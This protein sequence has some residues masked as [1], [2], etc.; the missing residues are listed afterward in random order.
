MIKIIFYATLVIVAKTQWLAR[1]PLLE[2][3]I[4]NLTSSQIGTIPEKNYDVA[5][6]SVDSMLKKQLDIFDTTMKAF[7]VASKKDVGFAKDKKL[8]VIDLELQ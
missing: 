6:A 4:K 3:Q 7:M 2:V 5:V 8:Q 1:N